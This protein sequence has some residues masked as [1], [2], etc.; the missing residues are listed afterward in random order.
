MKIL[1]YSFYNRDSAL[2]GVELLGKILVRNLGG[3]ILSGRIVEVEAYL[4]FTDPAAHSYRGKTK[5]TESLFKDA[6]SVYVYQ[7]H[8]QHCMDVVTD[9]IDI[10]GSVLI[11]AIE[12][13]EGIEKMKEFRGKEKL[14]DL[15]SGP[16]KL[17]KA[18]NITKELD[19]VNMLQENS[20]LYIIDDGSKVSSGVIKGPRIG[21]SKAVEH[22]LR[23]FVK[24]SKY[25]S[26]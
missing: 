2:V 16:G 26:R 20:P 4:P 18:L 21:I 19:G 22:E 24:D 11:R 8:M 14:T 6:G 15:T 17:C 10:P 23:F 3:L 12:P 9:T 7:I 25:I 13:I 5:R 1:P